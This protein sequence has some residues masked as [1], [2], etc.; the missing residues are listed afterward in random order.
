MP[1]WLLSR[2]ITVFSPEQACRSCVRWTTFTLRLSVQC[3]W[4]K[5]PAPRVFW[6]WARR[7]L[8]ELQPARRLTT[9]TVIVFNQHLPRALILCGGTSYSLCMFACSSAL[10]GLQG[11]ILAVQSLSQ[12]SNVGLGGAS[13][14]KTSAGKNGWRKKKRDC[15]V[16][17]NKQWRVFF[18]NQGIELHYAM[19]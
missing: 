12:L 1:E 14:R 19:C 3:V 2:S 9:E 6:A 17:E 13:G 15:I 8:S 5:S 11:L 7:P 18:L 10:D 16:P 4:I